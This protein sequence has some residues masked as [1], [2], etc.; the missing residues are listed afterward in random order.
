MLFFLVDTQPIWRLDQ[1]EIYVRNMGI[2]KQN[3]THAINE[4]KYQYS[5]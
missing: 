4:I 2:I 1:N 5:E 3:V